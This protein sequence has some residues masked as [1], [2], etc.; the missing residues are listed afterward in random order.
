MI[1]I[2][3][4]THFNHRK[5]LAYENRPFSSVEDM[6]ENIIKNWNSVVK[7]GDIVIHLG[8]VA[9]GRMSEVPGIIA[10][11][12]GNK[13]FVR[14][15][16][17]DKSDT[18]YLNAGFSAVGRNFI[19]PHNGL[20][21]FCSHHPYKPEGIEYDLHLFGHVHG[22]DSE[23]GK[24]YPTIASNGACLCVERWNY[25]P[26]SIDEIIKLCTADG[27]QPCEGI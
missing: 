25:K 27:V 21:I 26:V 7:S 2:I 1:Y 18:Y 3:S 22:V 6:N 9:L 13:I 8:D 12:N 24:N 14:G 4:D 19:F 23:E 16:H 10:R 15:N 20:T 11:L 5:I 17:D